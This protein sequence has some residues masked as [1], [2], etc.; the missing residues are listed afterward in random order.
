MTSFTADPPVGGTLSLIRSLI[1]SLGPSEQRVAQAVVDSAQEVAMLSVADLAA[2]TD[3]S[4]ATV[5]R[6]C[7]NM[8]FKGFH[9][10]RLLLLR[11]LGSASRQPDARLTGEGGSR[12][13]VPAIFDA[14]ARDLHDAL[15]ALDYD[16]F[17]AAVSAIA[18]ARRVLIV[19]NGGSGPAAQMVALRFLTTNRPCEAPH[20]SIAQQLSARLLQSGDVCI[21]VSDSGMNATTLRAV[22]AA[23]TAG[24][25]VI[26]VTSYARSRLSELSTH[27][28]VAGATFHSWGDGAITGNVAQVMILS[29]L[30]DA[31]ARSRIESAAAAPVV[32]DQVMGLV[33]NGSV[34]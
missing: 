4:S 6:T 11:D 7:Q 20:D 3:T 25:T 33:D 26:G 21:A 34:E 22:E 5:I 8:G 29:A 27:V 9:H 18:A 15:G 32:L 24:V 1:P 31:V 16:Q 28:L 23:V 13:R 10:L 19:A 12:G 30:Q 17:D 14:A 2:R